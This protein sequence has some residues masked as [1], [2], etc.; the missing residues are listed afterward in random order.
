MHCTDGHPALCVTVKNIKAEGAFATIKDVEL[1]Q[2]QGCG[3]CEL[4]KMRRRAFSIKANP[5]DVTPPQLGKLFTFDVL[6]LRVP[7]EHT[8]RTF[9]SSWRR[10][11]SS[12]LA[13]RCA[14]TPSRTW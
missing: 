4:N 13:V 6:E 1:F 5:E 3:T 14:A 7:A 8:G 11:P 2:N 9:T 12:P 10:C